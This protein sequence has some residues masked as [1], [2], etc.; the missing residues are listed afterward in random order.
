MALKPHRNMAQG[1]VGLVLN[2]EEAS[3]GQ[4]QLRTQGSPTSTAQALCVSM[5]EISIV[6]GAALPLTK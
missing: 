2:P 6:F 5:R 1:P 4:N 3:A